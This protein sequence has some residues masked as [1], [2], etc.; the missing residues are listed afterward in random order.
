MGMI[1]DLSSALKHPGQSFPFSVEGSIDDVDLYG[2]A[3]KFKNPIKVDGSAM[4]TGDNLYVRGSLEI[5]YTTNCNLCFKEVKEKAICDFNE[6]YSH[7]ED[8]SH[9]D[10][11]TF[12]G[13]SIDITKMVIDNI[14]LSIPLKH[15]CTDQCKGLCPECGQDLNKAACDCYTKVNDSDFDN[16]AAINK[17]ENPFAV[18]GNLFSDKDNEEA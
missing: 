5:E 10:R 11:Y 14:C 12:V 9:P 6:E 2:D 17:K 4:N 3:I 13:Y 15:L 18:L 8:I 16:E 1:L 7:E